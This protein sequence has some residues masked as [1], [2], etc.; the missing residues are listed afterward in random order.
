MLQC[1][2]GAGVGAA[3]IVASAAIAA[4]VANAC[5][6]QLAVAV[7]ADYQPACKLLKPVLACCCVW[8][9]AA[10]IARSS[11][12][13]LWHAGIACCCLHFCLSF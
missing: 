4:A 8:L 3:V 12:V 13:L 2:L 1:I 10:C 7:S 6:L 11:C 9:P 5:W